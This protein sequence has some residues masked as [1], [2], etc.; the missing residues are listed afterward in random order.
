MNRSEQIAEEGG[1]EVAE[2]DQYTA[3]SLSLMQAIEVY[4]GH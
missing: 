1:M 3:I 2:T 4:S